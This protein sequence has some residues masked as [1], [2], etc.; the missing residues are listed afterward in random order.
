MPMTI[1]SLFA[2]IGGFELGLE[3]AGL[4]PTLW[5]V[6]IDRFCRGVLAKHWPHAV[7]FE[8]V[9]TVGNGVRVESFMGAGYER[10]RQPLP[11]VD[12][13]CGGFPCQDVSVAGKG[14]GL[15]GDRSGLWREYLR[16]VET[17]RPRFVAIEN[18][19]ALAAR[20]L[21]TVLSDLAAD[22]Y[23]AVWF[24]LAASDVGAPH[25]R[26]RL[27]VVARRVSD[28]DGE[29]LRVEQQRDPGRRAGVPHEGE[30]VTG[31]VGEGQ[32]LWPPRSNDADGWRE[33]RGAQPGIRGSAARLPTRLD[34]LEA[35]GNAVVPQ[36]AEVVG[37][38]ILSL[39]GRAY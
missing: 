26:E 15:A 34:R 37:H 23:D 12:V 33:W 9:E 17:V 4:G 39:A 20:G 3:R 27:F 2:G 25:T 28:A 18:V 24:P 5:Q 13:I 36:C 8:N 29:P 31:H 11:Y 16:I 22:G 30:P 32:P 10:P 38:V 6:E 21:I 7:R 14:A 19:P 1:G 35:L